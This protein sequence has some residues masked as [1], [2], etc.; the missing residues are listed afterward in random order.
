[1]RIDCRPGRIGA[2]IDIEREVVR[3]LG[4][5]VPDLG[6]GLRGGFEQIAADEILGLVQRR[7]ASQDPHPRNR[8]IQPQIDG[9]LLVEHVVGPR[10]PLAAH[11]ID[12][13]VAQRYGLVE[14]VYDQMSQS[15]I[16]VFV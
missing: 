5:F 6:R 7:L 9:K 14:I 11:Q 2:G 10:D 12:S 8:P 16:L 13:A 4:Q 15:H 3:L 1:M